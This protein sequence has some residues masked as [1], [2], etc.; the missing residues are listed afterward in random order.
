LEANTVQATDG[1]MV[2]LSAVMV[3]LCKPYTSAAVSPM[4][5]I[6]D[7]FVLSLRLKRFIAFH[8]SYLCH[9]GVSLVHHYACESLQNCR[10]QYG[11]NPHLLLNGASHV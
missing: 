9:F 1:F 7:A 4:G 3:M 8:D 11:R 6:E 10:C 5:K 2:N